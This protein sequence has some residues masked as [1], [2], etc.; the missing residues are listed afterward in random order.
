MGRKEHDVLCRSPA[1]WFGEAGPGPGQGLLNPTSS[2]GIHN[3][4]GQNSQDTL[5]GL[6]FTGAGKAGLFLGL[7]PTPS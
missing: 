3:F 2:H 5:L 6:R 1:V 4:H 7:S